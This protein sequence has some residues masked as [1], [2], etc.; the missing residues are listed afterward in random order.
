MRVE[1]YPAKQP[2]LRVFPPCQTPDFAKLFAF[3]NP[4]LSDSE[5]TG[6]LKWSVEWSVRT[7]IILIDKGHM[8]V[9]IR[10]GNSLCPRLHARFY[11]R[12]PEYVLGAIFCP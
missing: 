10:L 8:G 3:L 1:Q 4:V 11:L 5:N 6:A 9:G 12:E 7:L 2:S